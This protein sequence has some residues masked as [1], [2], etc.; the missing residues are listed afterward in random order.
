[1]DMCAVYVWMPDAEDFV[2]PLV[3]LIFHVII[4]MI[5]YFL[6]NALPTWQAGLAL[7]F[8]YFRQRHAYLHAML[9]MYTS[10]F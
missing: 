1:M 6:R 7:A 10:D 2:P 9:H 3:V 8:R 4:I 5:H